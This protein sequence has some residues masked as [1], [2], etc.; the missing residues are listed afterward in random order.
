[1][2]L[3][4]FAARR[5]LERA[6]EAGY[7]GLLSVN[8][9]ATTVLDPELGRRLEGR[10]LDRLWIELSE[11]NRVEDYDGLAAVLAPW[12]DRGLRLAVDDAGAGFASFRHIL[13][14]QPDVVKLD[15]DLVRGLTA[16]ERGSGVL[17]LLGDASNR[18]SSILIAEGVE[19]A[20]VLATLRGHG[21]R[22]GHGFHL[23]R[24]GPLPA[25][26]PAPGRSAGHHPH[27]R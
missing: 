5:A 13:R 16:D 8:F 20:G 7:S 17:A 23:G 14:L 9:S 1:M 12:R 11:R 27:G 15:I 24:P 2:E 4:L 3:E 21:L 10:R 18:L 26:P 6:A 25:G 22:Y 19:D